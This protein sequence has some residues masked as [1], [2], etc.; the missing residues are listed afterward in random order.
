ME[1]ICSYCSNFLQSK[2][3]VHAVITTCGVCFEG[4]A[5]PRKCCS[6][7]YCDHCYSYKQKCP[8]CDAPTKV[9]AMTGATFMITE[10]SEHEECR[11][12]L[13][14]GIKR[15][16]CG[17]YYCDDCYYSENACRSCDQP[18]VNVGLKDRQANKAVNSTIILGWLMTIFLVLTIITGILLIV[19]SE[20]QTPIGI[21]GY[22]C[23]GLYRTCDVPLCVEV[24]E[25]VA[26]GDTPLTSLYD[27]RYCKHDTTKVSVQGWGCVFDH[28]LYRITGRSKGYPYANDP[29]TSAQKEEDGEP[30]MASRA[31]GY[32][33]CM[34]DYLGGVYVFEDQFENWLQYIDSDTNSIVGKD[35]TANERVSA[36]WENVVNGWTSDFCGLPR[37]PGQ[38]NTRALTFKGTG[39]RYA[40]TKA[41]DVSS[42]GFIEA[43]FLMAPV[44][45]E[46]THPYCKSAADG[47]VVIEYF[48]ERTE[49]N[50]TAFDSGIFDAWSWRSERYHKIKIAFEG[51][52]A[53][54]SATKFR[55][56]QLDFEASLDSWAIDNVRILRYLP[57]NWSTT[58]EF[59]KQ[60]EEMKKKMQKA[61]CCYDTEWCERRL[62]AKEKSECWDADIPGYQGPEYQLRTAEVFLIAVAFVAIV[63]FVYVSV[64]DWY[65]R[66]RYPF[67]DE[68]EWVSKVDFLM[69]FVPVEYRPVP[70][71]LDI[72]GNVHLS[73][74]L[75]AQQAQE[76]QD[77]V[78]EEDPD[79]VLRRENEAREKKKRRKEKKKRKM[80]LGFSEEQAAID[81]SDEEDEDEKLMKGAEQKQELTSDMDKL[82]RSNLAQLRLP[83]EPRVNYT[84]RQYFIGWSAG[85]YIIMVLMMLILAVE[86]TISQPI[87]IFDS[88]DGI[89]VMQSSFI[90]FLALVLDG[91]EL[92]YI[93]KHVVPVQ[94]KFIP[95]VTLDLSQEGSALYIGRYTI[96][97]KDIKEA[98][99]FPWIFVIGLATAALVG[100]FPWCIFMLLLREIQLEHRVNRV[101]TPTLGCIQLLRA[102][103]G[104]TFVI[105][106]WLAILYLFDFSPNTR[107][108]IGA[109]I[110]SRRTRFSILVAVGGGILGVLF[111][112]GFF[113]A[114][115]L[116]VAVLIAIIVGC[117][118]GTVAG[119]VHGLPIRPWVY[120][121]TV[122]DGTWLRVRRKQRCPCIYWANWCT[123]IH[124]SDEILVLFPEDSVRFFQALK[125]G[126]KGANG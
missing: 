79:E 118:Y 11:K 52:T 109:A 6:Q 96:R 48:N 50:W 80:K 22:P 39:E 70:P 86:Y 58:D 99:T 78:E 97:L 27:W 120:L 57:G 53:V 20:R 103:L 116:G 17:N 54:H 125:G 85:L 14:P 40:Q 90:N 121:T 117:L 46:K 75:V 105:K 7:A 110:E 126:I 111:V 100:C 102:V 81:S 101:L 25:D 12:C 112:V 31:L 69:Q 2:E 71:L 84:F 33:M 44:D 106:S 28:Q 113:A 49:G 10:H 93:L 83:F 3:K 51:T 19:A 67:Q 5:V 95:M 60:K 119:C 124:D 72:I 74:R 59:I 98:N 29:S 63:K 89:V 37:V 87:R 73:A 123:D 38:V 68:V 34:D 64:M 13:D 26:T 16:C 55:F 65:I 15:R 66:R 56:R 24:K 104:P 91:K 115:L 107:E 88:V 4:G 92:F 122:M 18:V 32:E 62:T 43:D 108:E 61:A 82:K 41:L 35:F 8:G 23:T 47:R 1:T 76:L 9:E 42:G 45:F 36:L 77:F 21:F 114:H 30:P 94:D